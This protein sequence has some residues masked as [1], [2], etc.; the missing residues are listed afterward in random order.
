MLQLSGVWLWLT[1]VHILSVICYE[2]IW[3]I[4]LDMNVSLSNLVHR[5]LHKLLNTLQNTY[6]TIISSLTSLKEFTRYLILWDL[7]LIRWYSRAPVNLNPSQLKQ[8][9]MFTNSRKLSHKVSS[10]LVEYWE[11]DPLLGWQGRMDWGKFPYPHPM[12]LLLLDH[13]PTTGT[14]SSVYYGS[15]QW[16]SS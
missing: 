14:I 16:A 4:C 3:C 1:W 10:L 11:H 12:T 9:Q 13:L 5:L 15:C 2:N 8:G 6:D 7:S